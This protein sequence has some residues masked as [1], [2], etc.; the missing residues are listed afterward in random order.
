MSVEM[1]HSG[2]TAITVIGQGSACPTFPVV[3]QFLMVAQ[4]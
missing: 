1:G 3:H 2:S 4:W